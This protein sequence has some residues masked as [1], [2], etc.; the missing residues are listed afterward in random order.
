MNRVFARWAPSRSALAL[1]LAPMLCGGAKR[2]ATDSGSP[3]F[4]ATEQCDLTSV[5]RE[6]KSGDRM[7]LTDEEAAQ[8]E[9]MRRSIEDS[10]APTIQAEDSGSAKDCGYG[11]S[12]TIA[13]TTTSGSMRTDPHDGKPRS[14]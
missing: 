12:G 4:K 9:D 1:T 6:L 13:A 11:F 14:R 2:R 7:C 5:E 10:A 3:I 8:V